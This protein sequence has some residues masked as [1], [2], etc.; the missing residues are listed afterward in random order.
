[1]NRHSRVRAVAESAGHDS[2]YQPSWLAALLALA[3]AISLMWAGMA[4]AEDFAPPQDDASQPT[5]AEAAPAGL[6]CTDDMDFSPEDNLPD[7]FDA[8][9]V[10]FRQSR[11]PLMLPQPTALNDSCQGPSQ[12]PVQV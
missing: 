1:M 11:S 6:G 2:Y 7:P 10:A 5:A 3:V 9:L 4:R 12:A 8:D